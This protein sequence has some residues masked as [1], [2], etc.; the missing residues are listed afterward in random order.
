M[1]KRII[2]FL[3]A[4]NSACAELPPVSGEPGSVTPNPALNAAKSSASAE[5]NY[6]MLKRLEQLQ[7]EVQQLTG[8]VEEQVFQIEE[9]K[10]QQK[11]M[12]TDFD[13]RI[14]S[15][16]NKSSPGS[17]QPAPTGDS[18]NAP[19]NPGSDDSVAPVPENF[20]PA[21]LEP[22]TSVK[23]PENAEKAAKAKNSTNST[24]QASTSEPAS[25][26]ES[27]TQD[28]QQ[29]YEA[30]R[31]GRTDEAING[32]KAYIASHSG[33]AYASNS[34]Y[35][36]GEA[37]RVNQD[38]AAARQAF[39][40]VV[41]KYPGSAKVPDALLKLGYIEMEEKNPG[42]AREYFNRITTEFASSKAARLA[43]KKLPS[44][45]ASLH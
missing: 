15:L 30:L 17:D 2:L 1:D 16:E 12:Y 29:A 11:T 40:D 14:Q 44:L 8:K 21:P 25:A 22:Q 26:S 36:L 32:F 37:Y 9:L 34:Q 27:E 13:D 38:N 20:A 35:W 33:G 42:K 43:E 24:V 23:P 31:N 5:T 3:C 18:G 41:Q 4:C 45:E 10:K 7:T 28:Y 39:N 6:E 19:V